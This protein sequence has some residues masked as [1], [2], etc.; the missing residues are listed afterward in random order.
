M[1]QSGRELLQVIKQNE[2]S[3]LGHIK[4]GSRYELPKLIMEGKIEGR[5][6]IG[7]R[8]IPD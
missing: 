3:Y 5:H 1:A 8:S 6:G 2:T 4:R 7:R